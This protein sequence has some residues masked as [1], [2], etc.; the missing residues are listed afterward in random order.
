MQFNL[1]T[2][3]LFVT[4]HERCIDPAID[5]NLLFGLTEART[6]DFTHQMITK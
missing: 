2:A 6:T 5:G 3:H 4:I 1:R